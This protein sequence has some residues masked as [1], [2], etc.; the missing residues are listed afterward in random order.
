VTDDDPDGSRREFELLSDET[1]LAVLRALADR[2]REAP[3]DPTLGFAD[4]RRRVGRPDSGNFNYHLSRLEGRFVR[5]TADGYRIAPAGIRVVAALIS[6][7]YGTDERLGPAP[8]DDHCPLCEETLTATYEQG[9]LTVACPND[10]E[11]R[12]S[13]PPG[14]IDDRSLDEVVN[15]LTRTTRQDLELAL[16]DTCPYC[17]G[18]LDWAVDLERTPSIPEFSTACSRCGVR[19]EVPAV[20]CLLQSADGVAFFHDRG[21]DVRRRPLWAPEFYRPVSV[22][23]TS[24]P[25][26]V[27]VTVELD[28]DALTG[29]LDESLTLRDLTR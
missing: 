26:G 13:L 16:D 19:I 27:E 23:T 10:H 25:P 14:A 3:D 8:L 9:L 24:E 17:Y 11:F 4:L 7:A 20:C 22:T 12:N 29:T 5:K 28:G 21:I 6:G 15:L 2:F 1:R 18:R